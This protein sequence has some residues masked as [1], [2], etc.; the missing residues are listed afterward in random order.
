[1][2]SVTVN[3]RVPLIQGGKLQNVFNIGLN[4]NNFYRYGLTQLKKRKRK[5]ELTRLTNLILKNSRKEIEE[6][7]VTR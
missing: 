7:G 2:L 5:G 6:K 4:S 3:N 1:M